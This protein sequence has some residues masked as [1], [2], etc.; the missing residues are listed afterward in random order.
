M[1]G[2]TKGET[3]GLDDGRLQLKTKQGKV[4]VLLSQK[5]RISMGGAEVS[6]AALQDGMKVTVAGHAGGSGEIVA[7][8]SRLPVQATQP[9]PPM[10][11][12][13]NGPVH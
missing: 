4:I 2:E 1:E 13:H 5:L 11:S 7:H 9:Q 6:A 12:G 10:P 8:E 3:V